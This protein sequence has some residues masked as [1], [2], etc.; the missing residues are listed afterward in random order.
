MIFSSRP[1]LLCAFSLLCLAAPGV[2]AD[3][4]TYWGEIRP[5]LRKHC[6][7]CH[8]AKNIKEIDVSGG[9]GLDS[10]DATMKGTKQPVIVPGKSKDSVLV[11]LLT[12]KDETKRM[13]KD[14]PPLPAEA[15]ELI[16]RWI[17]GGAKEGTK[18]DTV[19]AAPPAASARR[20]KKLDI[21]LS[22]NAVPPKGIF[23][24]AN[25][26]KLEL[27]LK[28]GPLPPVTAVAY[29]P[30]GQRLAVGSYGQVTIWDLRTGSPV[31]VL[32]SVLGAVNDVRFSPDG[33]LLAVGGGQP[34]ARGDLR[35]FQTDTWQLAGHLGGHDDVVFSV[36]F[37]P[38][39]KRLAS[40]SFDKTV[41][42]WELG[43]QKQLLKL[44]AHSDFVYA[45]SFSADGKWLAS[46]SKDKSVKVVDAATGKSRFTF[47][48]MNEDVL[49]TAVHPDGKSVVSSGFE[50]A[51]SWWAIR[52]GAAESGQAS[53]SPRIRNQGG[54]GVAVHELTFSKDGKLLVSAGGD[55]TVR[56]WNGENGSSVR[57]LTVGATTYAVAISPDGK[58]I[59]S[60]SFDGQVRLWDVAS[61]RQLVSLLSLPAQAEQ[62]SWIAMTPEGYTTGSDSAKTLAEWRMSGQR[63][64]GE[65]AWKALGNQS[66]M[67]M[68]LRGEAVPAPVFAK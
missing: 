7:V 32:T 50:P 11:H 25:P 63:V 28:A 61:G 66:T 44:D 37:S 10:F 62:R 38:D 22:T 55:G 17:D 49:A 53:A 5:L 21:V 13:P 31:K 14:A 39:S 20:L 24:E 60:G 15:V 34:S 18:P 59:A 29:S 30:D 35:L 41:R 27:T 8:S 4:P 67:E 47:S 65:S 36:S 68:A 46:C 56:I 42:I 3:A 58:Q 64:A 16:S 6:T 12:I 45:V 52:D 43:A 23:S 54:H 2:A 26:A 40:A 19:A 9:L 51:I 48:G 33:K 57:T 1:V